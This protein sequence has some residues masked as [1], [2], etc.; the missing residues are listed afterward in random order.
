MRNDEF[1]NLKIWKLKYLEVRM[2]KNLCLKF[3]KTE[4][5]KI[6]EVFNYSMEIFFLSIHTNI[7]WILRV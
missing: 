5:L 6:V 3:L 4:Y 1:E 2:L 7:L